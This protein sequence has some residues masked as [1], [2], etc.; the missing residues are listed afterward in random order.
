MKHCSRFHKSGGNLNVTVNDKIVLLRRHQSPGSAIIDY[1][2]IY[3]ENL[4]ITKLAV[5]SLQTLL[6]REIQR[7]AQQQWIYS[8]I[9]LKQSFISNNLLNLL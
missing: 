6:M 2:Y 4:A 3:Q 9:V 1:H 8:I 7:H 5:L